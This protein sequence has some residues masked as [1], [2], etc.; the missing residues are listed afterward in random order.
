MPNWNAARSG[1]EGFIAGGRLAR[2]NQEYKRKESG[3]Q[4]LGGLLQND[5][6]TTYPDEQIPDLSGLGVDGQM[7]IYNF[8]KMKATEAKDQKKQEIDK[9]IAI[10]DKGIEAANKTKGPARKYLVE[11]SWG[12]ALP[13]LQKHGYFQGFDTNELKKRLDVADDKTIGV[14]IKKAGDVADAVRTK[15]ITMDEAHRLLSATL[16]EA[17]DSIEDPAGRTAVTSEINEIRKSMEPKKAV[18]PNVRDFQVGSRTVP[19]Q[20]DETQG[21]WSP[22]K[23]MGG[24]KWSPKE[25]RGEEKPDMT[26]AQAREKLFN[27]AKW[28]RQIDSTGGVDELVFAMIA[29]TDP[30]LAGQMQGADKSEAKKFINE[31]KDY[32]RRF[33]KT[34]GATGG[35]GT[36]GKDK[37]GFV[38]GEKRSKNGKTYTYIG[39]NQWEY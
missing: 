20:W 2:E 16:S 23:G 6:Q 35:A 24:P 29:K 32:Y 11:Q 18:A 5:L 19:H 25:I 15:T 14:F 10:L 30:T 4:A 17:M 26:E 9:G 27:L 28:E 3:R 36:G 13:I 33:L 37:F 12:A 31:Q 22:V 8:K 38:L 7:A 34:G 1:L 39:N 21:S